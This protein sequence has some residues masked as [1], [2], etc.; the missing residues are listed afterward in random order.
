MVYDTPEGLYAY[1]LDGR[2]SKQIVPGVFLHSPAVSP[3][4]RLVA[5]AHGRY[6][7]LQNLSANEVLIVPM[8]GGSPRRIS[9]STHVNLSPV[10]APDG[11][12]ILYVSN[13]GGTRDVVQQAVS[14]DGR[15]VGKPQQITTSL[16]SWV[17]SLSFDGSR[18]AYD[19]VRANSNI[20]EID[21]T[22]APQKVGAGKPVTKENQHIETINLSHDGNWLIYDSDLAGNA[23]IYKVRIDGG[24]PVQLTTNPA[25]D[26]A[27]GFSPNDKEVV[28]HSNRNGTRDAYI[29]TSEGTDERQVTSGPDEDYFPTWSADGKQLAFLRETGNKDYYAIVSRDANGRWSQPRLIGNVPSINDIRWSPDGSLIAL[30]LGDGVAVVP[31]TGSTPRIVA[32]QAALGGVPQGIYWAPDNKSIFVYVNNRGRGS[33]WNVPLDGAAPRL[34]LSDEPDAPFGR[35]LFATDGKRLFYTRAAWEADVWVT[36][37]KRN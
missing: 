17:I 20:Y 36:E 37:L 3:D 23:D 19:A 6:P 29:V 21:L 2:S 32:A 10:W 8:S 25:N 16:G 13:S 24:E 30:I 33:I 12:S 9:D 4:G 28:F 34:V 7:T 22:G 15:P 11:R 1:D 26:F 18:M 31:P 5:Y 35:W 14:S 27:P